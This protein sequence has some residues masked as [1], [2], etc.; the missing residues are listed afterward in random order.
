MLAY[1]LRAQY[2]PQRPEDWA[3]RTRG[4][5]KFIELKHVFVPYNHL[6]FTEQKIESKMKERDIK[7][8]EGVFGK[9]WAKIQMEIP[10]SI[11]SVGEK[12]LVS[13]IANNT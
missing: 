3:D 13:V 6:M 11:Y 5:S 12:F 9:S 10:K 8:T 2:I 4:F 1:Y 7:I